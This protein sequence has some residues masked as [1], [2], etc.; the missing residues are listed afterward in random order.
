MKQNQNELQIFCWEME[1]TT[2]EVFRFTSHHEDVTQ[3]KK[4]FYSNSVISH[5]ML[6]K[7][8]D[9][10]NYLDEIF[11]HIDHQLL[12]KEDLMSNKLCN[13]TLK[14]MLLKDLDDAGKNII[15]KQYKLGNTKFNGTSFEVQLLTQLDSL[16]KNINKNYSSSCRANFCDSLCGLR[17]KDFEKEG[18]VEEIISSDSFFDK[19]WQEED[20]LL[21]NANIRFTTGVNTGLILKVIAV[22]KNIIRLNMPPFTSISE[23]DRYKILVNC[24][25][26]LEAC[27]GFNNCK[28]FR[29]EPFIKDVNLHI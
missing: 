7:G 20:H 24:D 14:V 5:N 19:L 13:A 29:G 10:D 2:K 1:L 28:N 8:S 21:Y 26:S 23:G 11:I 6:Q 16:N 3:G 15:L 9:L 25:K 17:S 27:T 12:K 4:R 18:V 22:H